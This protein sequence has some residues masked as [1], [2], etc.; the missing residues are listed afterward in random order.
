M[1]LV[2]IVPSTESPK[3]HLCVIFKALSQPSARPR[4][5][6]HIEAAGLSK[7]NSSICAIAMFPG[8]IVRSNHHWQARREHCEFCAQAWKRNQCHFESPRP[9][10]SISRG[11]R[12]ARSTIFRI[13][14]EGGCRPESAAGQVVASSTS[15]CRRCS[16]GQQ[17]ASVHQCC[18]VP[19]PTTRFLTPGMMVSSFAANLTNARRQRL[20]PLLA[21]ISN[22]LA[23]IADC[24]NPF[25][26]LLAAAPSRCF[27]LIGENTK[28]TPRGKK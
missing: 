13:D 9:S 24:T 7:A 16:S 5:A 4:M 14:C 10:R 20:I 18:S 21:P 12:C 3:P 27:L 23:A 8:V 17:P 6:S 26:S 11:W 19:I 25:S 2:D 1:K 28:P 15:R 22:C